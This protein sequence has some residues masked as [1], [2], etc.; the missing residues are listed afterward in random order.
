MNPSAPAA[1]RRTRP[2]PAALV[3]AAGALVL[4]QAG[5]QASPAGKPNIILIYSDDMYKNMFN[6]LPQGRSGG[7]A[8]NLTPNLD[9][10]AAEGVV[11]R[12]FHITSPVCTPSRY[13]CLTGRYAGRARNEGYVAQMRRAGLGIITWNTQ[14][15]PED[16]T[17]AKLLKQAGYATGMVGKNHT[18]Q[19]GA[20]RLPASAD[21]HDPD[22]RTRLKENEQRTVAGI[23]RAGFDFVGG[24]YNGNADDIGPRAVA[25][26]NMEWLT[27]AGLT[28]LDQSQSRGQDRPFF[29][30]FAPT[31]VHGPTAPE[32]S[33]GADPK[34]TPFGYLDTPPAVQPPRS[35]LPQR[36]ADAGLAG[37]HRENILWLDDAVGAL[38]ARIKELGLE[39][40]TI[41][42]FANDNGQEDKGSIYEGG[43]SSA[44]FVWKKGGFPCGRDTP[45]L[46]ANIDLAPTILDLAGVPQL[47]TGT[48]DGR[49]FR[50]VLEGRA[51]EVRD[52]LYLELGF[53]RG[54]RR[55]HW[56]YIALRYP[57]DPGRFALAAAILNRAPGRPPFGHI[58]G[59]DVEQKAIA[60][61]PAYWDPDQLFDLASDPDEQTNLARDPR[62]ATTLEEMK[63]CLRGHL[64]AMPGGFAEFKPA[65]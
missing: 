61:H 63:R 54:L 38:L 39:D 5:A 62:H 36:L 6:F 64:E 12:G 18:I 41:I 24:I 55:G 40:N 42:V 32:R 47:T 25:V 44:A 65:E 16:T 14:I 11:L 29:L 1:R 52:E 33:W 20:V 37:Q 3:L 15:T 59:S 4:I 43:A 10:L 22:V 34:V 17:L 7:R 21:P 50:P 56:K 13:A 31:L 51:A 27:A 23:R 26:H 60:H 46:L 58:A 35:S 30:Y 19:T 28:F 57:P 9:R 45:A 8:L 2:S 49:S 48:F 53:T